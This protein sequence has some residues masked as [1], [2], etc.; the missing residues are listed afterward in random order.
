[1]TRIQLPGVI[2]GHNQFFG[3]D[4][5]SAR[6]GS[7]RA[8][9]FSDVRRVLSVIRSAHETGG[10]GVMLSTH[11]RAVE[12][13]DVL[14][15]EPLLRD[16]INVYPLL[17]YAQKYVT[18]ANEVGMVRAVTRTLL[19]SGLQDRV[20]LS[21]DAV[22]F[23]LRRDPLDLVRALMSLELRT[24]RRLNMPVVFLHDAISDLLLGLSIP[25]V[26]QEYA[27]I[28]RKRFGARAGVATKNLPILIERFSQ[29]GIEPPMT[30]TH[31]NKIGFHVNPSQEEHEACLRDGNLDVMA[32]GT[33]ASGYL[34]SKEAADYV[35]Q[36]SSV[37]LV[38]VGASTPAHIVDAFS[39]YLPAAVSASPEAKN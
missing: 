39:H 34:K 38:V 18:K 32:M 25:R 33:L 27:L 24:F 2:L 10:K 35:K 31:V 37:K 5:L 21:G 7:E 23:L 3:V 22:R 4:H 13:C 9:Q 19:E 36:F 30:L 14:R 28:L 11:P 15:R 20:R 29:W 8:A 26:F 17:P 16:E 12:I 6:R 1:M